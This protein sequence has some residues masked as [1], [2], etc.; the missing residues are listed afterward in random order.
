M[1]NLF[2][3]ILGFLVACAVPEKGN[4]ISP[5]PS[6]IPLSHAVKF[7]MW[8]DTLEVTEPW[9]GA[10]SP[11]VYPLTNPPTRVVVTS[12]THLPFIEMLGMGDRLVGFPGTQYISSGF[13]ADRVDKGL[14]TELGTAGGMNLELLIHLRPDVV[15]AYDMG[16]ESASL[17]KLAESGIPVLYNADYL[18]TSALGRAEWIRFFGHL[19]QKDDLA[20]SLF[21]V[22]EHNYDSL[23]AL[24]ANVAEQPTV[25]SG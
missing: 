19:F 9:R 17:D 7:R 12:T 21:A 14:I 15:I 2:I 3:S 25:F 22:I 10:T 6:G 18:E 16:N 23:K 1:K 8:E 4:H 20:D 11:Q 13:F 5:K 24:T